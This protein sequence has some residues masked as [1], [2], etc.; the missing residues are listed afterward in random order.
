MK[1]TVKAF[2]DQESKV[3]VASSEDVPGLATEADNLENLSI[4]LRKMIPELLILNEIIS[5]SFSGSI[6]FELTTH[7]QELI[8]LG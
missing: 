7:R 5:A 2:W 1:Y 8:K 6:S 4:K 3:W